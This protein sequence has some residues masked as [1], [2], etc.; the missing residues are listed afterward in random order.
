[1]IRKRTKGFV[2]LMSVILISAILLVLVFV[3]ETWS[4]FQR[5]DALDSE[6]K[7]ISLELAESCI[8]AAILKAAQNP[9]YGG[10]ECISL[11]GVCGGTD[12]Q[13]VCRICSV[14]YS[15]GSATAS[16]RAVFG[17]AFTNLTA[18]FNTAGRFAI[19]NWR[20]T[21]SG[22]PSCVVP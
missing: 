4:F 10:G 17:Q 1:M 3:L 14:S 11:G 2:A 22:D 13:R 15:Y 8:D 12:P 16:T 6:N 18:T 7:R 5:I 9:S 19:S 21:P 20:E